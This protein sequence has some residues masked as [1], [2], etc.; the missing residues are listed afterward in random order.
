MYHCLYK[1]L[2]STLHLDEIFILYAAVVPF[3]STYLKNKKTALKNLEN[4][5]VNKK[6][7]YVIYEWP[8]SYR[9]IDYNPTM[10][11]TPQPSSYTYGQAMKNTPSSH[12]TSGSQEEL[13]DREKQLAMQ[14]TRLREY[15]E[16]VL[17]LELVSKE[18]NQLAA[19]LHVYARG[20]N[21]M[22]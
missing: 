18:F 13:Y 17:R 16:R 2:F 21:F 14:E 12:E 10:A 7:A 9:L 22:K 5:V 1:S 6:S 11:S 3:F 19:V 8:P 15:Q 4:V 20:S